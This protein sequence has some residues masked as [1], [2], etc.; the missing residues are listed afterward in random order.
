MKIG[1]DIDGVLA[2][3]TPVINDF[4]N[5][6]FGTSFK[7]EDYVHFDLEKTWNRTNEEAVKIIEDFFSSEDFVNLLPIEGSQEAIRFL[8]KNHSLIAITARP[9]YLRD[10]T[11]S[12]I[13]KHFGNSI[14][15]VHFNNQYSK[16]ALEI[17]KTEICLSKGIEVFIEDTL[18]I[19]NKL[20][21]SG[22]KVFLLDY[23]GNQG[24][25]HEK[26]NIGTLQKSG[27]FPN[28]F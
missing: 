4:Y 1:I 28:L 7:I 8:S 17:S 14:L 3:F 13:K 21:K 10:K 20:A 15:E 18:A 16:S 19:S 26:L 23:P 22:I 25:M 2:D 12:W 11:E 24:E 6:K 27:L 5:N 9:S